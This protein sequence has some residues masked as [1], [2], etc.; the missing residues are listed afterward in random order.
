MSAVGSKTESGAPPPTPTPPPHSRVASTASSI[1]A[2]PPPVPVLTVLTDDSD[3]EVEILKPS[4]VPNKAPPPPNPR[5]SIKIVNAPPKP[6]GLAPP[7]PP[8]VDQSSNFRQTMNDSQNGLASPNHNGVSKVQSNANSRGSVVR[9]QH[10]SNRVDRLSMTPN[11]GSTRTPPKFR[12]LTPDIGALRS[13]RHENGGAGPASL[14]R[15]PN[16]PGAM[17]ASNDI[18]A[19]GLSKQSSHPTDATSPLGANSTPPQSMIGRRKKG[20]YAHH[21]RQ[22]S[23]GRLKTHTRNESTAS[24]QRMDIPK[25]YDSGS[26]SESQKL[27]D[28]DMQGSRI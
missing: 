16:L 20:E 9:P 15:M 6:V 2:P 25:S 4:F 5:L 10:I 7:P 28:N 14:P 8:V 1:F 12:P 18:T 11:M 23:L 13:S 22:A 19:N 21:A 24:F 17:G 26:D 27:S 3:S